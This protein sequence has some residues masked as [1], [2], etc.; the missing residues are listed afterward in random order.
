MTFLV[1][2]NILLR[3]VEREHPMHHDAATAILNLMQRGNRLC[4]IPQNLI[5]FWNV[6]T[7]P[8]ERNGLGYSLK[9][10]EQEI[11]ELKAFFRLLPDQPDIYPTWEAL[12]VRYEVR[13]V[14]VHDAR[15]VAAMQTHELTH[16][17]TFNVSDFRR[18]G[19]I[20]AIA[21]SEV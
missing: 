14:N 18:Y 21:P 8:A 20:T 16:I 9:R 19:E 12:V 17:L 7:R 4:V 13:G 2:T 1:D 11:Q 15:L 10:V 5:E 3:N 6:A